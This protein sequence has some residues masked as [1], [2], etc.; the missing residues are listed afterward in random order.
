[1]FKTSQ[2]GCALPSV[3]RR[4]F[5]GLLGGGAA[6]SAFPEG[7][8]ASSGSGST[9]VVQ[10]TANEGDCGPCALSNALLNGNADSWRAFHK[11]P[12]ANSRERTEALIHKYGVRPSETY[13]SRRGRFLSGAGLTCEDMPFLAN[14]VLAGAGLAKVQGA[15]LDHS[16][17]EDERTHLRRLYGLLNT[18]LGRGFPPVMEIRAFAADT[19]STKP[20]WVNLYAH[21]LALIGLDPVSLPTGAS[22]FLCRFADSYT[23]RVITGFAHVELNRAFMATRGFTLKSDGTQ[24]WHWLTG[25]PYILVDVPDLPLLIQTRPWQNRALVAITYMIHRMAI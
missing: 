2:S 14:D 20:A 10:Q 17:A 19:A 25:Q 23:G 15:W 6:A 24:D 22:G 8:H 16:P 1:M 13:G 3:S 12:G 5:L 4:A 21:W 9:E 18:S 7:V 11:L